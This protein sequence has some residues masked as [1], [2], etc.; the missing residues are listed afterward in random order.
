MRNNTFNV[1][2][3]LAIISGSFLVRLVLGGLAIALER[4]VFL[5]YDLVLEVVVDRVLDDVLVLGVDRVLD[6]VLVLV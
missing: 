1:G 3:F 6:D 5:M 4:F 2:A